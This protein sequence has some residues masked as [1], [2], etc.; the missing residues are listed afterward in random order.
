M[1]WLTCL[2]PRPLLSRK[3]VVLLD[4]FTL[5]EPDSAL[6][7]ISNSGQI[8]DCIRETV[9]VWLCVE[10]CSRWKSLSQTS[11]PSIF[12]QTST[13]ESS[14]RSLQLEWRGEELRFLMKC[15]DQGD[16]AL[17]DSCA[18]FHFKTGC[19]SVRR[20]PPRRKQDLYCESE[21]CIQ[22]PPLIL[23]HP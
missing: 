6:D 11:L 18:R 9:S 15:I 19:I 14:V 21:G 16:V 4:R 7:R 20:E 10:S 1:R 2:L 22:G 5:S 13:A 3:F 23:S 12:E 8:L 17:G